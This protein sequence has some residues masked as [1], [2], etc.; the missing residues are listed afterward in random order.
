MKNKTKNG[1][2]IEVSPTKERL[3][4]GSATLINRHKDGKTGRILAGAYKG[5]LGEILYTIKD[6]DIFSQTIKILDGKDAGIEMDY[7]WNRDLI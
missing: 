4:N 2:I 3:I 1:L 7:L 5:F 6:G